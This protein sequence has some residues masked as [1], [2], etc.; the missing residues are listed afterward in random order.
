[1]AGEIFPEK[2][3]SKLNF[4]RQLVKVIGSWNGEE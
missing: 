4:E 3:V 1:M 2:V